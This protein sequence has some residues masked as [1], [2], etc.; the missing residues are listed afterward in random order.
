[1]TAR[2]ARGRRLPAPV[3]VR[4][5]R[6]KREL[7]VS[8]SIVAILQA[9]IAV[10]LAVA[11]AQTYRMWRQG[12]PYAPREVARTVPAFLVVGGVFAA[13]LA[14]RTLRRARIVLRTP[15]DS[16]GKE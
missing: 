8:Y 10:T 9:A 3:T 12:L 7:A 1:M 16:A 6:E 5:L 14:G 15:I 2:R 13:L 11:A 4:T